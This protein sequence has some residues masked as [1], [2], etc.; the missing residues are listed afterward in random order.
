MLG[1]K[2][3]IQDFY[4]TPVIPKQFPCQALQVS[5]GH[6]RFN[7]DVVFTSVVVVVDVVGLEELP[8]V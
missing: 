1:N 8:S 2:N 5:S 3:K 4:L 7:S 6:G